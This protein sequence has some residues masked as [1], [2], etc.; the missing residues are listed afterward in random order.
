MPRSRRQLGAGS[1]SS[2]RGGI[3]VPGVYAQLLKQERERDNRADP[4]W[5]RTEAGRRGEPCPPEWRQKSQLLSALE[6]GE[7]VEVPTHRLGGRTV[8]DERLRRAPHEDRSIVRWRVNADDVVVP[9][10]RGE[11]V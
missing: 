3:K 8:P 6:A 9:L 11:E 7:P 4:R 10:R 1:T 5:R 2:Q